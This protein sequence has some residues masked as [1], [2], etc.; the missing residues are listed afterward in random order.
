[1]DRA[2]DPA[3]D[4]GLHERLRLLRE[5]QGPGLHLRLEPGPAGETVVACHRALSRGQRE[6]VGQG[7]D[8]PDGGGVAGAGGA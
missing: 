2:A 4:A 8:P 3:A 6:R 7:P 1:M 5:V